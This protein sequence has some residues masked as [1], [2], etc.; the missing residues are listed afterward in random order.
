MHKVGVTNKYNSL[1]W[2]P[3]Y[4]ERVEFNN[5]GKILLDPK[6]FNKTRKIVRRPFVEVNEITTEDILDPYQI[7]HIRVTRQEG[8]TIINKDLKKYI[9]EENKK[10]KWLLETLTKVKTLG[11][12][13][14]KKGLQK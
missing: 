3:D 5:L 12:R 2:L 7:F 1:L 4:K 11:P 10:D 14:M 13:S 8:V 9:I 6:L